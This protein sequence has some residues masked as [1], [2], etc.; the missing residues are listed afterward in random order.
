ME[1]KDYKFI[2]HRGLFNRVDT[3]ENSIAAFEKAAQKG[4][5]I[6]FDVNMTMDGYL[7]V[8]HD[9]TLKRMTGIKNDITTLNLNEIKKLKLIGTE[10]RIPTFEDVLMRINGRVPLMIEIK[11]NNKYEE[12]MEK[13]IKLLEKYNGEYVIESFDPRIIYWLK[14]NAP[15]I[16]RGQLSAKNIREVKNKAMK[17]LLGNMAF[18]TFTKPDFVSYQYTNVDKT[19]YNKQKKKGRAVAVWT[20]KSKEEYLKVK[21]NCDMVIFENEETIL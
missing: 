10:H 17:S 9:S 1:I 16:T 3:P 14:K 21:D 2:A 20:V 6:E 4:Y 11:S 12:L 5:A 7:V 18:N 13:A 8:F 15:D 19:F